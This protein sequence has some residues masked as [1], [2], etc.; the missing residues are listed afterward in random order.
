MKKIVTRNEY[1]QLTGLLTVGAYHLRHLNELG[2]AAADLLEASPEDKDGHIADAFFSP[3]TAS[4]L[5]GK[6][7][8]EIET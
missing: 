2:N 1:L 4:E 3:Y 6:L 7:G 8:I 5:I